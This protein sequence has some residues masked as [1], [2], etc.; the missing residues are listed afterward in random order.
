MAN[1]LAGVIGC[2]ITVK[3]DYD[4]L[5]RSSSATAIMA[6][7]PQAP[8]T[9]TNQPIIVKLSQLDQRSAQFTVIIIIIDHPRR[10]HQFKP[11]LRETDLV[12]RLEDNA[13]DALEE[14]LIKMIN[15]FLSSTLSRGVDRWSISDSQLQLL[16][17]KCFAFSDINHNRTSARTKLAKAER[18]VPRGQGLALSRQP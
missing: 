3:F 1:Y 8:F 4:S 2:V 17:P 5:L 10:I 12:W 9:C 18:I 7:G 16:H 13:S 11:R 15:T 6:K 14:V